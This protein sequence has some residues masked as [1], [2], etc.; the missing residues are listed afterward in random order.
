MIEK[1]TQSIEIDR[2]SLK[3]WEKNTVLKKKSKHIL[4]TPQSIEIDE[5]NTWVCDEM[6]FKNKV[7]TPVFK[8]NG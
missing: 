5:Q 6:Y 3:F 8:K 4:G 2:G 7:L 1:Q